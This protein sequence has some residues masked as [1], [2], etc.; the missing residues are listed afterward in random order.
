MLTPFFEISQEPIFVN[1]TE[2]KNKRAIVNIEN[3]EVLGI[4]GKKYEIVHNSMVRDLFAD[5]LSS[6]PV[7]KTIDHLDAVGK[8]WKR[9][10]ILND[11]SLKFEVLPVDVVGIMLE[12]FNAYDGKTS[13]GYEIFGF[14]YACENGLIT[15]KQSMF[16]KSYHHFQNN[17]NKLLKDFESHFE[18][19]H[20]NVEI[21]KR[22]T[23]ESMSKSLFEDFIQN[24]NFLGDRLKAELIES[25]YP[26]HEEMKLKES[27]WSAFQIITYLATHKV[28]ARRGSGIFS[29]RK[30]LLD[31]LAEKF[32]AW[33]Q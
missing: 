32:Y 26:L 21:W 23:K 22:W 5:A 3:E 18:S 14:R 30:S 8:R 13:F 33:G 20:G 1:G 25:Y 4:V 6:Y 31:L 16:S 24:K 17:P 29:H 15:G 19:F 28:A 12:I 11:D 7:L 9:Q 10:I 2:V 27:M